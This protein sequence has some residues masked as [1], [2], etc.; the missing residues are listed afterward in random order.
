LSPSI[1]SENTHTAENLLAISEPADDSLAG[2]FPRWV[3]GRE[4]AARS[5]AEAQLHQVLE[6]VRPRILPLPGYAKGERPP[7]HLSGRN[8]DLCFDEG[9]Y[10]GDRVAA[11]D[12]DYLRRVGITHVLNAAQGT[13]G[14]TVDTSQHFYAKA[15]ITYLG[16]KLLDVPSADISPHFEEAADF[17]EGALKGGG[18][19]LVNCYMGISRSAT[20]C[21]GFLVLRRRHTA[22][23]ALTTLRLRRHVFPNDGFISALARL[24]EGGGGVRR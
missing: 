22:A 1:K 16:F 5:P 8:M 17:I 15:G 7:S 12:L 9:L 10:I 3:G 19:V 24:E 13:S 21:C 2:M 11:M 23:E 20:L 14:C 6:T 18:R 4:G